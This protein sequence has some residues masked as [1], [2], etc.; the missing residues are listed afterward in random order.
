VAEKKFTIRADQIKAL[1][2]NRGAC[3]ATDMIT[4]HGRKVGYMSREEPRNAEDSGWAFTSGDE[5][6]EYMD[7]TSNHG[8]YDVNTIANYDPDIIPY[9]DAPPGVAFAREAR[10]GHLTQV[11]GE[12]WQPGSGQ[13]GT[14]AIWP[15]TGFPVVEGEHTLTAEWSIRLPERFARRIED[16]A[17][18]L[19]R[20]GLTIWLSVWNNDRGESRYSRLRGAKE[21]A[22]PN[23][24]AES[25]DTTSLTR[26]TYRLRDEG[27][28]GPVESVQGFVIGDSGQVQIAIYFDSPT[29]EVVARR[30]IESVTERR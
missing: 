28:S 29:D 30:L 18:V 15:P 4:V 14:A 5:S 1:A 27:E 6:Q 19:W 8:I 13:G 2:P 17:L 23:R 12:P 20:P 10:T 3:I 24:F 21:W 25:E 22:S 7:D 11:G 26:Y 16:G 9:L